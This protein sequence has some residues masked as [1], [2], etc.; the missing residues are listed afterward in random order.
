M[1]LAQLSA[2]QIAD[3]RETRLS[4]E[5]HASQKE[6]YER[7]LAANAVKE[8]PA[9][10]PA[11]EPSAAEPVRGTTSPLADTSRQATSSVSRGI[12]GGRS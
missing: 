6:L 4:Q 2:D 11:A 3:I 9:R 8:V 7:I 5:R 12:P 1:N 10:E